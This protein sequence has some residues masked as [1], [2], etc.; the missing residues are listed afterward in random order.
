MIYSGYGQTTPYS[1]K[2]MNTPRFTQTQQ[3][4]TTPIPN[5]Y[6]AELLRKEAELQKL[7]KDKKYSDFYIVGMAIAGL[8]GY[9]T[10]VILE[11]AAK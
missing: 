4:Y 8:M 11:R 7:K 5:P 6:E 10:K 9:L 3:T 1:S 2:L